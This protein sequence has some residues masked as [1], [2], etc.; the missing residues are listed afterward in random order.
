MTETDQCV[1]LGKTI[2]SASIYQGRVKPPEGPELITR[3]LFIIATPD[4]L[5]GEAKLYPV[6]KRKLHERGFTVQPA[7]V[8]VAQGDTPTGK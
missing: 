3:S 1:I 6:L 8:G 5:D 2:K 4:F 7:A